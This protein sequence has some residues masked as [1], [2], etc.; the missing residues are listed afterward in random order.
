MRRILQWIWL[1]PWPASLRHALGK[2]AATPGIRAL[3][4]PQFMVGVVGVILDD[5]DRV[6]LLRHTY[7]SD[8][9]W[10]L[11]TGFLEHGEQPDQALLR[12]VIEETGLQVEL[13]HLSAVLSDQTRPHLEVVYRGRARGGS[14]KPSLEIDELRFCTVEELPRLRPD[15]LRL[16]LEALRSEKEMHETPA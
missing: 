16:V 10:G 12:E 2:I 15:Q 8:Y 7:R 6:L 3:L 14:F 4:L 9:P 11:P 1:L 5:E 13:T